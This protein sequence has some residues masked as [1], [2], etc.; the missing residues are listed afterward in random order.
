MKA[1]FVQGRAFGGPEVLEIATEELGA[2]GPDQILVRHSAVGVNFIDINQRRGE[3]GT[4]LPFRLGL[5][6]AGQVL[7]VGPGVEG[8]AE[9]DRVACAGGPM[10]AYASA[11]LLPAARAVRLPD[12]IDDRTAAAVF[13]KG[14]TA[15]YLVHRMRPIQPGDAVLF[16]AAAGGLGLVAIP[17]LKR[18]GARVIGTVGSADKVQ[19]AVEAG[20]DHVLVLP[21]APDEGLA[22][23]RDWTEGKGVAIAYDSIG[24]ATFELS[25]AALARFGLLVSYGRASGDV[26]PLPL[27]RLREMGSL[28][29]TRPTVGDYTAARADLV[30]GATRVFEALAQGV[31]RPHIFAALP[32]AQAGEAH[33][34]IE[35]RGTRG[36]LILIP[37]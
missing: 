18:A 26:D 29:V 23:I 3:M 28:F 27:A 5:E 12:G 19:A 7:A 2:P 25:L 37:S 1:E 11:R 15:D 9:G 24:R 31:I 22:R 30:A 34:L 21:V 17:M 16:T 4:A 35:A 8:L 6:A 10:G 20:C 13:F 33:R 32:L 14:L 36:S